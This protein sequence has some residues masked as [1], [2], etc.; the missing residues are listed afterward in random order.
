VTGIE[1]NFIKLLLNFKNLYSGGVVVTDIH[2]SKPGEIYMYTFGGR[3]RHNCLRGL[4]VGRF[5]VPCNGT[6][7]VMGLKVTDIVLIVICGKWTCMLL[8]GLRIVPLCFMGRVKSDT[9]RC[10]YS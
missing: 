6:R 1:I 4:Q 10:M 7:G 5:S 2:G 3:I 9:F 8:A